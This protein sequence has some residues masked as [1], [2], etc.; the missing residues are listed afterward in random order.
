MAKPFACHRWN[1]WKCPCFVAMYLRTSLRVSVCKAAVLCRAIDKT[2]NKYMKNEHEI[3]QIPFQNRMHRTMKHFDEFKS[4]NY[5][6]FSVI[7]RFCTFNWM[8]LIAVRCNW[9]DCRFEKP[10]LWARKNAF[11]HLWTS[12][13]L[14]FQSIDCPF[15]S[16]VCLFVYY[17]VKYFNL[18]QI[19]KC[20]QWIHTEAFDGILNEEK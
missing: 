9:I 10:T 18:P 19:N 11:R 12:F 20:S 3:R 14:H 5:T 6:N 7:H 15:V 17:A 1:G 4:E 13:H 2:S 8:I 16:F